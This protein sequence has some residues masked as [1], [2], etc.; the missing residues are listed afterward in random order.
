MPL[1]FNLLGLGDEMRGR[2]RGY[3][4]PDFWRYI[5]KWNNDVIIGV[6]AHEPV[7]LTNAA[8][9]QEAE[10]RLQALDITPVTDWRK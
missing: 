5:R 7:A 1:E 9:W 4:H 10:R 3:P 6:D 8:V 2:H